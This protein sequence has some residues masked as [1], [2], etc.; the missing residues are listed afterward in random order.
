MYLG[1]DAL[2]LGP[3]TD[4]VTYLEDGDWVVLTRDGADSTTRPGETVDAPRSARSRRRPFWSTRATTAISWRRKSTSSP[5]SS[6]AR[7]PIISTCRPSAWRCPSNCR[8]IR[9]RSTRV[10][11]AGLRHRL[12]RRPDRR[13]LV[14][15]LRPPAGRYRRRLRVPLPR[16]AARRGGLTLLCRSPARPPTRSPSLRYAK[17]H[18]QHIS[19]PSSTS[20]LRP[21]RAR[22]RRRADARRPRNRRRLDQGLHLPARGARLPGGRARPRA[23]RARRRR[24]RR[25]SSAI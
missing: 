13:I 18:G 12:L 5:R 14:R 2:A 22:R 1:S 24:R 10:T 4:D 3:F 21:S 20:R 11:I 8:S 23:R 16:G 6:A 9:R 7:S 17:A 15:A 25:G 19:S